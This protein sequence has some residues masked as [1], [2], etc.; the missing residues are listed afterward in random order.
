MQQ[1][2]NAAVRNGESQSLH[3]LAEGKPP[4]NITWYQNSQIYAGEGKVLPNGTLIIENVFQDRLG[5]YECVAANELGQI[6]SAVANLTVEGKFYFLSLSPFVPT[7]RM[8][9]ISLQLLII[10]W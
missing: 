1:P 3:C 6:T 2:E 10:Q 4:P 5:S 9:T 8:S 7:V